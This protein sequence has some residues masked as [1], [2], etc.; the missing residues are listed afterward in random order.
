MSNNNEWVADRIAEA[1]EQNPLVTEVVT[2]RIAQLLKGPLSERQI[3]SADIKN[4]AKTLIAD[5]TPLTPTS[6]QTQ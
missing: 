1:S 4:V 3:P 6:D 5:M 2:G